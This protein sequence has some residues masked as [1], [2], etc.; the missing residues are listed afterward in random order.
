MTT[1]E[2]MEALYGEVQGYS[3]SSAGRAKLGRESDPVLT[4]GEVTPECMEQ[5]MDAANVQPGEV[6]YDLGCGTG[7]AVVLSAFLRPFKRC[8]GVELVEDLY[9]SAIGAG[10]RY[11]AEIKPQLADRE[12]QNVEFVLGSMFEQ[13]YSDGDVFY[14]HCT[15]FDDD[16][17]NRISVMLEKCKPG[18][19]V[20]TITKGLTSPQFE[21]VQSAP[22]RMGWG[23]ATMYLYKK[24]G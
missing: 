23:E 1:A 12:N 18:T 21:L 16:M 19:R 24:L 7:K 13:D 15:C 6:F 10:A 22:I 3:L 4:Y 20:M 11:M 9:N 5:M 14:T 2:V 17:M 8:V